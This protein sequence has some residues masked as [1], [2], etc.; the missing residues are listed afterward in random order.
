ML[1]FH[2]TVTGL[3]TL[4]LTHQYLDTVPMMCRYKVMGDESIPEVQQ[5]FCHSGRWTTF[6]VWCNTLGALY[7]LLATVACVLM[8]ID[9]AKPLPSALGLVM[10][11]LWDITLPMSFLVNL[12]VT[13]VLLPAKRKKGDFIGLWYM[14]RWRGQALHNGY[15]VVSALEGLF[16]SPRMPISNF[17]IIV[18]YGVAYI[19]FSYILFA[20]TGIFHY[21]FL[22]PRFKSAPV[23]YIGLVALLAGLYCAA[24]FVVQA[25]ARSWLVKGLLLVCALATCTFRDS[26]AVAPSVVDG[27]TIA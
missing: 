17:P 26:A 8:L 1:L 20:R 16:V 5:W 7:F 21:F 19:V 10:A 23:A 12:I 2:A 27:S 6:T 15:V 11:V 13:F 22:D 4:T 14:L 18:I 9:E 3:A 25:A 24:S